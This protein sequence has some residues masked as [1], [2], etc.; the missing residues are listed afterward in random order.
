MACVNVIAAET[1]EE[2]SRLATSFYRLFLGLIRN[3]RRPLQPPIDSME[4]E[5]TAPEQAAVQQMMQFSFIGSD[6]TVKK[7]L[8]AFQQN[9]Q[10]D[11]LMIAAHIYEQAVKV[12]SYEL[13][14][15]FFQQEN[16][17]SDQMAMSATA[18]L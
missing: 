6:A 2:A 17:H 9:A 15:P 18:H 14:A 1:D 8:E 16:K 13:I 11:E 5:W 12:R 10:L 4:G 3:N 7:K